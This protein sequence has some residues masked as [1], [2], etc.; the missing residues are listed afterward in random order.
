M[1]SNSLYANY[2]VRSIRLDIYS[3]TQFISELY[4]RYGIARAH[5]LFPNQLEGAKNRLEKNKAK[6]LLLRGR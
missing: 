2:L 6:L 5:D 3:D 1:M 4:S